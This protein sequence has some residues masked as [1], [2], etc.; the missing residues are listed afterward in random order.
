[1][2]SRIQAQSKSSTHGRPSHGRLTCPKHKEP[3]A[4]AT[5]AARTTESEPKMPA[6]V[7]TRAARRAAWA[8]EDKPKMPAEVLTGAAWAAEDTQAQ[9][10][11][12]VVQEELK[13]EATLCVNECAATTSRAKRNTGYLAATTCRTKTE[14][15]RQDEAKSTVLTRCAAP[16]ATRR[17]MG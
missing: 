12:S 11:T 6:E 9:Q 14:R 15:D 17:R 1:M 16:E 7:M 5:V 10:A 8:A 3:Q 2:S 4:S 13:V